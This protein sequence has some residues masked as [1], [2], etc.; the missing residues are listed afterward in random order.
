MN[1]RPVRP[2]RPYRLVAA[3]LVLVLAG[4]GPAAVASPSSRPTQSML[5]SP[6]KAPELA[7][8]W[9]AP[10]DPMGLTVDAGLVPESQEHLTFHSH[11]H[12]DVFIDG[13]PIL[14]PAGIGI[15]IEDPEVKTFD[16]PLGPGYGGIQVCGQPCI[17]P[18]HT[19]DPDGIIHTESKLTEPNTLGQFF[20]EWDVELSETCVG[21]FCS[22][23]K[24][25]AF[26]VDGVAYTG[27]PREI[28]LSD[29]KEIAIVI[30]TPPAVIPST[31][32]F[33]GA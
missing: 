24:P 11:A 23:D 8:Q 6:T 21:E 4:C 15:N 10:A 25:V 29:R 20:I 31:G 22:P 32:D 5:T 17:S 12:L 19:H 3:G 7:I 9:P 28:E 14:V 27:D 13:D 16:G 30:G 18:L 2:N 26:Y 1:T 33:S